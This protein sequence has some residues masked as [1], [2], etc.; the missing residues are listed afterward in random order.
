MEK[1]SNYWCI[2]KADLNNLGE[3]VQRITSNVENLEIVKRE[4]NNLR[5]FSAI[6]AVS[7]ILKHSEIVYRQKDLEEKAT[8]FEN[9]PMDYYYHIS[10]KELDDFVKAWVY[11]VD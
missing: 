10:V 5:K 2:S 11:T 7:E 9:K 3:S 1:Q 6:P 4:Y 8:S